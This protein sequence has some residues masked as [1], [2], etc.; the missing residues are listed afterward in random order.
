MSDSTQN[1]LIT[2]KIIDLLVS[3]L[4]Q[5]NGINV[6]NNKEK[7]SE[8]QKQLLKELVNDLT[9]QVDAFVNPANPDKKTE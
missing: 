3:D 2:S 4:F 8:E 9:L 1:P 5:K 6:E 7:L